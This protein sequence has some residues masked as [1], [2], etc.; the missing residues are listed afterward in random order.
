MKIFHN[1]YESA[2]PPAAYVCFYDVSNCTFSARIEP[3]H[4]SAQTPLE[5]VSRPPEQT[6]LQ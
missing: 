4:Q 3:K 2:Y 5:D 1:F 6:T